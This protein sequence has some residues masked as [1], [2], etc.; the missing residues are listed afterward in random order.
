MMKEKP[1]MYIV[2]KYVKASSVLS[3]LRKEPKVPVHD[4]F[5]DENWKAT[6]LAD[7]IGFT[8][9]SKPE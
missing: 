4:V 1:K 3:A 6:N 5:V 8:V 9:P 2:R 7:A